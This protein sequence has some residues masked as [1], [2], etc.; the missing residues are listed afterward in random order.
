M[1]LVTGATGNVGS[2]VAA[3]LVAAGQP[4]R[5]VIRAADA[6]ANLPAGVLPVVGDLD[7]AETL[8]DAL[9]GVQG[10]F[11]L[12]GYSGAAELLAAAKAAGVQRLVQLS[13]G[14][15]GSRDMH[16][17]VTA[18]MARAEDAATGSGLAWT[19]L[20]PNAFMSN[21]LRWLPQLQRGD[22]LR[23][24]FADVPSAIIDPADI[25]AVAVLALTADGHAEKIYRLTG[26]QSL[27]PADQVAELAAALGRSLRV[28]AQTD[29]EARADML[30]QMPEPY[31]DAFLDFYA[32]GALDESAVL[33]TV[34][35]LLHR[36]PGNF[37]DWVRR[38][39]TAF[40]GR[41]T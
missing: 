33:P 13:G 27:T 4:V 23:L 30:T 20:R 25:G 38:H 14:S 26:P 9:D 28:I 18:Y 10:L 24:P 34:E 29:E 40:D 39:R 16:N 35:Q 1:Y 15:A 21:A 11:L 19:V 5:G 8:M 12:P 37:T 31:V 2:Q 32:D 6:A 17:A 36:P 7:R 41:T 3:A 22:E